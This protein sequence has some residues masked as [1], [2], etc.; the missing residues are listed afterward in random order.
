MR[1]GLAIAI[2]IAM[3]YGLYRFIHAMT[4]M[5]AKWWLVEQPTLL[6]QTLAILLIA[7][8]LAL[9]AVGIHACLNKIKVLKATRKKQGDELARLAASLA[10]LT[11]EKETAMAS[12]LP[13]QVQNRCLSKQAEQLAGV[14]AQL[15][16]QQQRNKKLQQT[17][18]NQQ[19]DLKNC[20][21]RISELKR[22]L[23]KQGHEAGIDTSS[24]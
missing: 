5:L 17:Q 2:L 3:A 4:L 7:S 1:Y 12:L 10:Q 24:A 14:Q 21:L 16:D 18:R 20:R 9:V 6:E 15:A 8:L 22:K 11:E 23:Q 19:R 13:L